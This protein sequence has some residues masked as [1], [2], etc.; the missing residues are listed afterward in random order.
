MNPK[1]N[2]INGEIEKTRGK[3]TEL[4]SRLKELERQKTEVENAGILSLV[5]GIDIAPDELEAFVKAYRERGDR[6]APETPAAAYTAENTNHDK[7]DSDIE[8]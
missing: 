8:E 4:Q 5:R 2:K 6:L 7:E 1:I 3:I